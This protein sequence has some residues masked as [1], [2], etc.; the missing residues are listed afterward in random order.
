[1]KSNG[2]KWFSVTEDSRSW[3]EF[4][5]KR[6]NYDYSVRTGHGVNCSMACSWEVFVKDGLICWELQKTDYPQIDPD[7]PN[8]EPRGCQRGVTASWYPYSPLRP[9]FPYVRKVLWDLY[10][11]ERKNGKDPVE[12]Y[13]SIV[14]DE[15]RSKKY[16]SARGKAGWKRVSWD[17]SVEL[18]AAGQIHTIKKYGPDHMANFS[19]IPAM[20]LLSFISGHRYN[21]LL[22]G[23]YCSYYEWYHDLPH[24]S[25]SMFG[26]QTENCES[27][28]WYLGTY[29]VVAGSNINMTRTADAHFLSEAKYRGS[30][31]VVLSPNYSDVAKYADT[32]VPLVPGSDGAFLMACIHV[33]LKEFYVEKE[34][35]Y[36]TEYAKQYTN[37][38]FLVVLD[39]DGDK[40]QMG[41]FLRASDIAEYA[42]EENAD[43]KLIMADGSGKLHVP[44]G[45]IGFRWEEQP[46]GNW[47]LQLKNAVTKEDFDP[48]LTILG[49]DDE[50]ATVSFSDFT[51]TFSIYI[52]RTEGKGQTAKEILRGVPARRIRTKDGEEL[53]VTTAFD[54][55]MAQA[56]VSRG[57]GGDYPEDY[58]DPKPYTPAWQ[59]AQTGVSKDLAIQIGREFADNAEKTKGK[60][61]FITGPGIQHFYHGASL[62][63][64]NEAVMLAL[65]GCNG[66]NGG[67]FNHYVGTQH[68]RLNA[69]FVNMSGALDWQRPP[70][71]M[72]STS[73]WYF[74]TGQW[75]YDNMSLDTQWAQGAK[76]L[77]AFNHAADMN[78]LAVRLGWLPFFP[79]I[80][81]KNSLEI[82]N[83]AVAA[84]CKSDDEVKDWVL[85]R[86][87]DGTYNF[88]IHDV[89]APENHLKMLTVYRGNLIGTSMRGH[90]LTLKHWL[91]TH[92]NVMWDEEPAKDLVNEIEW[93]EDS[94][95]GKLDF[96]V[97]LNIRMD[98]TANYSDVVLPA[99]FWY[100]KYDVTFGDMHTFVHPLTPA[101]QPPW[102]AKHDWEAFKLIAKKFEE[103]AKK[104]FP[105]P[106][107]DVVLNA[108][109]MDSPGQ[110]AQP[111]GEIK[112][113]R[114]GDT[115]AVAGKTFPS[116]A[117][118]ERD[119]T[120]IYDRLV[121]LG[122]LVSQP[123]GYG[124]K[125]QYTDLTPIVEEE[126]KNNEVLDI[127]DGR[128]FFEKPEQFCELILQISPELNG[129]LSWLF[130]KEME[131]KVGLPLA[132][133]VEVVKGRKVHYKDIIS[134]P[135]RIHTTPQWSAMLHDKDGKQRTFGPW[136]MNV[137]RLKPW[138]TLSGRQ[139]VYYDHQGLRELGEAL[140]TNKPPLDM[141]A[142][143]DINLDK[144]G[145]KSK[146]FRFITPHGKWQIHSS[147]RDHWPMMHMSR[148][149]PTVW[150]N[151]DD[152]DEIDV[153]DNDWVEMFCENGIEVVRAVVSHQV[154]KNM[155]ITYHQVERH[156][157]VPFSPL[158][159]KNKLSDLR[160]GN[161]NATTRILMNPHTMIGG[162]AQFSYYTNYWGTSPSER[163]HGVIIRKMPLGP[164]GK[165]VYQESELHKLPEE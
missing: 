133:M 7:I 148:G 161:N 38:P 119:Y 126:L 75:R 10:A 71:L 84:G 56:G 124:S 4:Y 19:P 78:A 125:G 92:N 27:S 77:P 15:E 146:V 74:Q 61:L 91:G 31:I 113:W 8:V 118:V 106:V 11:E 73:L 68:T 85:E 144:A 12:A 140:P 23:I 30:K 162:Y 138:H 139:E 87:K 52:G 137:E 127:K 98:S 35:P 93:H 117:I 152:S 58:N 116:I 99:A 141:V 48:L 36:F 83:E 55:T 156:V 9:K 103:L 108:T 81:K 67:N 63:Y 96:L 70:R 82:Y 134:Q 150:L 18:V 17:E 62:Y 50:E 89:D 76:K 69:A 66:V 39:K 14:E 142:I 123:K 42:N 79:Q 26:D 149:G 43:W 104:H 34:T 64:R 37:L 120:N 94:P 46:T 28:D 22:G 24:V 57:L 145:P 136:T 6:W 45:S 49:N 33:I 101:T 47:N 51:D 88:A 13:A 155:A 132:D 109:W 143:G 157:N 151:P 20:S 32:W 59:E 165:P 128:V 122:P 54:L 86:F 114:N 110:L 80:D 53:L 129:R 130:F 159:K 16:K 135:R 97:N 154:P 72:N 3:E 40:Y 147:F 160:G 131:K 95:I 41:R 107:K 90:E 115:E 164:D 21:N 153:K 60:S 2:S 105:E 44:T 100:E 158:A 5:R 111:L 163:D 121:S 29:W 25:S 112:D 65:C 102:E 1:M